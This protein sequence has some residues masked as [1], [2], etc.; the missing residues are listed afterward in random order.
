MNNAHLQSIKAQRLSAKV[1]ESKNGTEILTFVF[2]GA[3]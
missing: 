1:E 2:Y 3:I